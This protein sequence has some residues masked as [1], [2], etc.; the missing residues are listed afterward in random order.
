[1]SRII[2]TEPRIKDGTMVY[3]DEYVVL[4]FEGTVNDNDFIVEKNYNIYVD[5]IKLEKEDTGDLTKEDP[6]KYKPL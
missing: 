6:E 5:G 3:N 2:L 1:M 4:D